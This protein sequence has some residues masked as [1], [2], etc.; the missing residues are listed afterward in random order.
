MASSLR[1]GRIVSDFPA[2]RCWHMPTYK[3]PSA[4]LSEQKKTKVLSSSP[5][6]LRWSSSRPISRSIT[7][8]LLSA[9]TRMHTQ[10]W[11]CG[12]T[13][14]HGSVHLHFL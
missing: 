5:V 3:A 1:S 6:S 4:P 7:V 2:M 14:Y 13:L 8:K 9:T 10:A 11:Y 12:L